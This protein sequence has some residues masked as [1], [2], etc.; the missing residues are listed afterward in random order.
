MILCLFCGSLSSSSK[1]CHHLPAKSFSYLVLIK[2]SLSTRNHILLQAVSPGNQ[3]N[4]FSKDEQVWIS[5]YMRVFF[6]SLWMVCLPTAATTCAVFAVI[7]HARPINPQVWCLDHAPETRKRLFAFQ[8]NNICPFF[9]P[10]AAQTN[11]G[12]VDPPGWLWQ[13]FDRDDVHVCRSTLN[14]L[15][16]R[17]Q[18]WQAAPPPWAR[19]IGFNSREGLVEC[20]SSGNIFLKPFGL[21]RV[22]RKGKAKW[23][24]KLGCWLAD[25]SDLLLRDISDCSMASRSALPSLI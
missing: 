10:F 14:L 19:I 12:D 15:S 18:G 1:A 22:R 6:L 9:L 3:N 2:S 20:W 17:K 13:L 8:K 16:P 4:L 25:Q 7:W 24:A 21:R 23:E 5:V 11:A